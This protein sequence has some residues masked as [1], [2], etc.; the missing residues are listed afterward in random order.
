MMI[1]RT[2]V[3]IALAAAL[4]IVLALAWVVVW[5][6][7]IIMR[8]VG[9]HGWRAESGRRCED[10]PGMPWRHCYRLSARSASQARIEEWISLDRRT[11]Q[12]IGLGRVWQV[13]DSADGSRQQDS[14][15]QT[16]VRRGGER[17]TCEPPS[18]TQNVVRSISAW[19]F[20]EQEVR[21]I[22]SRQI[23]GVDQQADW[24]IQIDGFP[25]GYSGCQSWV[26][27]RRLLTPMEMLTALQHWMS[28]AQE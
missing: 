17:I 11:R 23:Q 21:M 13:N 5:R 19:R 16:L 26:R 1:T 6:P 22:T 25:V 15:A 3:R 8:Q 4:T 2:V 28:T 12:I 24:V 9:L 14:I 20:Q 7:L 10:A 18:D 27:S